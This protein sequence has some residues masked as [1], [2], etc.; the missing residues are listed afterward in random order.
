MRFLSFGNTH[1]PL[2]H[3]GIYRVD[4]PRSL[5]FG[6]QE[7]DAP[8]LET[9]SL[10]K[11]KDSWEDFPILISQTKR[12]EGPQA[13]AHQG[14]RNPSI[15]GEDLLL[16]RLCGSSRNRSP[17]TPLACWRGW[18]YQGASLVI[19]RKAGTRAILARHMSAAETG[20]MSRQI[21]HSLG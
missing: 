8:S 18:L 15:S 7:R 11:Q 20:I 3:P 1:G 10:G 5:G 13:M 17:S 4:F 14:R 16:L 9:C 19:S 2:V 21:H 12:I 6:T